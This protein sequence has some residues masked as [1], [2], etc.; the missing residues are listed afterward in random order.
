MCSSDLTR[1][2]GDGE[3]LRNSLIGIRNTLAGVQSALQTAAQEQRDRRLAIA[4][5][6]ADVAIIR[7]RLPVANGGELERSREVL[8][9][10]ITGYESLGLGAGAARVQLAIGD[11]AYNQ[12]LPLD[13]YDA[14]ARA[15]RLLLGTETNAPVLL[16]R[17]SFE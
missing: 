8:I 13:A 16:S 12:G 2:A 1:L 10:A 17:N 3:Q 5:G 7:Y 15:Y 6:D 14:Y 9:R 11:S 4:L